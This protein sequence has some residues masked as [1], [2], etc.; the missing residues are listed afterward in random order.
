MRRL[1]VSAVLLAAVACSPKGREVEVRFQGRPPAGVFAADSRAVVQVCPACT[2]PVAPDASSCPNPA[3]DGKTCGQ[4]LGRPA[5]VPCGFCR[6]TKG[7]A[8]C[9]AFETAGNCRF[10]SGVGKRRGEACFACAGSG[11]C[12]ACGGDAL[13]DICGGKGEIAFPFVPRGPVRPPKTPSARPAKG[14][15]DHDHPLFWLGESVLLP[16]LGE[17]R[18]AWTVTLVSD[19]PS[20]E[21]EKVSPDARFTPRQAG[22]YVASL[23]GRA[24]FFDVVELELRVPSAVGSGSSRRFDATLLSSPELRSPRIRWR[25]DNPDGLSKW[26]DGPA[27]S[28]LAEGWGEHKAWPAITVPGLPERTGPRPAVLMM[29]ALSVRAPPGGLLR[30]GA[31]VAIE[32]VSNPPLPSGI[33]Y[34]WTRTGASGKSEVV[35]SRDARAALLFPAAGKY[36]L[37]VSAGGN[38][39]AP[40]DVVAYRVALAGR[41]GHAL[42]EAMLAMLTGRELPSPE[43]LAKCAERFRIVVEDPGPDPPSTVSIS[44]RGSDGSVIQ[45]PVA[46]ALEPLGLARATREI[47]LLADRSDADVPFPNAA[48]P[49]LFAAPRGRVEVEYRGMTASV[50]GVGPM[51]VHEIPVRFFAVGPGFPAKEELEKILDRRLEEAGAVWAPYGRRFARAALEIVSPP[52]NLLLIRGRS[53]GVD[54]HGRPSRLGVRVDGVEVSAPAAWRIEEGPQTPASIARTFAR[55]VDPAFRVDVFERLIPSDREAVVLRVQ[56]RDG[57]PAV[58][59]P[60]Q[61]GQD[62]AQ[63][64]SLLGANLS[65]GCETTADLDLLSLEELALLLGLRGTPS[66]GIDLFLVKELYQDTRRTAYFKFYPEG[67]FAA[68]LVGAALVSWQISDGSGEYPY[69]LARLLGSLLL[70]PKWVTHPEDTLFDPEISLLP[71]PG[72]NKRVGPATRARIRERGRGLTSKNDDSS[73]GNEQ[74]G[75]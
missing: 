45:S 57:W 11:T 37:Q 59:E 29:S 73:K 52:C 38:V 34:E 39:S 6:D 35:V 5:K 22:S 1:S 31:P 36:R 70:P 32:A 12:S 53:A 75:R 4:T 16:R 44:V 8:P 48:D 43:W 40:V 26:V 56:R 55:R 60:I 14:L 49:T 27:L 72:A 7:C 71:G 18:T 9:A 24:L 61:E 50:A 62:V 33:P 20:V 28:V 68:P 47:A 41:D 25:W 51:I 65:D 67:V 69:A 30:S 10:C 42:P 66:E 2:R 19:G 54:A 74:G 3:K 21:P 13:C 64:V 63:G 17:A 15:V 23:G 58:L 46:Q